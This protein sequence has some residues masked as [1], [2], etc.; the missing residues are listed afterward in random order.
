MTGENI[1]IR[2]FLV[3]EAES[4][5]AFASCLA[6]ILGL[7]VVVLR[8]GFLTP[9]A[10]MSRTVGLGIFLVNFPLWW[11]LAL[12]RVSG[13]FGWVRR[14][15]FGV[16]TGL[17]VTITVF[18]VLGSL[19][20]NLPDFV[21]VL[22]AL[23]AVINLG[24]VLL[25]NR[26]RESLS[27]LA[28]LIIVALWT[29]G[30]IWGGGFSLLHT[31][32]LAL[33]GAVDIDRFFHSALANMLENYG[34]VGTGVDGLPNIA[35]H[36]GSHWVYAK[37][38]NL[39]GVGVLDF[40]HFGYPVAIVPLFFFSFLNFVTE[41]RS[42]TGNIHRVF[43][44]PL[45]WV[46]LAAAMI[47]FVPVS[48]MN[49]VS[50][51]TNPFF[52][53]SHGIGVA[54]GLMGSAVAVNFFLS[55]GERATGGGVSSTAEAFA[56]FVLFVPAFLVAAGLV[57]VSVLTVAFLAFVYAVGRLEKRRRI[58]LAIIAGAT[59][60]FLAM[61]IFVTPANPAQGQAFFSLMRRGKAEWWPFFFTLNQLWSWIYL[62][63]RLWGAGV[64]TW[65]DFIGKLKRR[66]MFDVEIVMLVT[67]VGL[68]P[69]ILLNLPS[70]AMYF[71]DLER[72]SVSGLFLAYGSTY[73]PVRRAAAKFIDGLRR[74]MLASYGILL[75]IV[76]PVAG[77]WI[78]TTS[79]WGANVVREGLKDR[80]ELQHRAGY[81]PIALHVQGA[82]SWAE[83]KRTG[84]PRALVDRVLRNFAALGNDSLMA[85]GLQT[86]PATPL[87]A[88]LNR[89]ALMPPEEKSRTFLFIPQ[90]FTLYWTWAFPAG[91][92]CGYTSLV[93]PAISGI[94]M[95][96]GEPLYG[97]KMGPG[98][99]ME[100]YRNRE[101]PQSESDTRPE[102][103]CVKAQAWNRSKII[104]L[105]QDVQ[106]LVIISRLNCKTVLTG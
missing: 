4:A 70:N 64:R 86:V 55:S 17:L 59:I 94:A 7:A 50:V 54:L 75:L 49:S 23:A 93:A 106:G 92:N 42:A 67:A 35:Y 13:T 68:A 61:V 46:V 40:L 91:P 14:T 9:V 30:A 31:E 32:D 84:N 28:L 37:W 56:F 98:F 88:Q 69:G 52:S 100:A 41:L 51:W 19:S 89:L 65:A 45:L 71:S 8:A 87:L 90:S 12:G 2:R 33:H 81:I 58:S 73:T 66:E 25:R 18:P 105:S 79:H 80:R 104:V 20:R 26:L 62:G 102:T 24:Q 85:R 10:G 27:G 72:W 95:I 39:A 38:S 21:L 74:G 76:G 48:G 63:V 11:Y 16:L 6:A 47:G 101:R 5:A 78:M 57:K 43:G 82:E 77:T 99:G 36:F 60:L 44:S 3:T 22:S 34:K 1:T 29:V 15:S 96:D 53:E 97:C 83:F 103:L